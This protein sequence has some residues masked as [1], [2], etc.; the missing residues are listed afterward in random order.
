MSF[1]TDW[2][3]CRYNIFVHIGYLCQYSVY[4]I[5][6]GDGRGYR[7]QNFL[8]VVW[9]AF[10]RSGRTFWGAKRTQKKSRALTNKFLSLSHV[11]Q[12]AHPIPRLKK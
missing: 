6:K 7:R 8:G 2:L 3:I 12:R 10:W 9:G 11:V 1:L 5:Y 4:A